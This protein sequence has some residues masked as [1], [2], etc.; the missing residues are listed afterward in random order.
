MSMKPYL[1]RLA[2]GIFVALAF[3]INTGAMA[4]NF[5]TAKQTITIAAG[6]YPST[7]TAICPPGYAVTG[8][9]F[10]EISQVSGDGGGFTPVVSAAPGQTAWVAA[11]IFMVFSSAPT[12]AGDGWTVTGVV[13]QF[14]PGTVTAYARC[15]M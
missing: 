5:V 10:Q 4:A 14:A 12:D 11:P 1:K 8:G 13:T 15:M 2:L 7:I 6:S 3:T 9:G